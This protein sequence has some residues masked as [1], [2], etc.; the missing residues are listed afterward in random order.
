MEV[1]VRVEAEPVRGGDVKHTCTA[2][3]TMVAL[4]DDDQ[5]MPLMKTVEPVTEEERRRNADANERR[6]VRLA[7]S[8]RKP[9]P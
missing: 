6:A 1:G 3:F 9:R 2:F 4:D 7:L 5:P 8:G